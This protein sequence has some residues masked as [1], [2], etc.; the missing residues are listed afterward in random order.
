MGAATSAKLL[1]AGAAWRWAGLGSAGDTL[2]AAF[3]GGAETERTLAGILLTRAG[4]RSVRLLTAALLTGR[5]GTAPVELLASIDTP[6]ARAALARA[7][8]AA[9]AP[10]IR[11]AAEQALRTLDR[12][13][14][15][16][17]PP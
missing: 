2:L 17:G 6:A 7:A 8:A 13:H 16:G 11:M 15:E 12:I 14:R 5:A 10:P 9:P 4:D 1:A 3:A